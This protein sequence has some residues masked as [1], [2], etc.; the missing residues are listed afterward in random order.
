MS[1]VA[2]LRSIMIGSDWGSK[3]LWLIDYP[4]PPPP[5]APYLLVTQFTAKIR[6]IAPICFT[7]RAAICWLTFIGL[8]IY[9]DHTRPHV[10]DPS[11]LRPYAL[12]N[13][14]NRLPF[15]G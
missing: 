8:Y 11:G 6:R 2:P 9:F 5:S 4:L 12:N 10:F 15:P 13:H 7:A 14:G 3:S 1:R